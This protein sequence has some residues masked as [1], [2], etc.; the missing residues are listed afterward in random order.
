MGGAVAGLGAL[1]GNA[2]PGAIFGAGKAGNALGLS[3]DQGEFYNAQTAN[4]ALDQMNQ[5]NAATNDPTLQNAFANYG[6]GGGSTQGLLNQINGAPGAQGLDSK[7]AEADNNALATGALTGSR[8]ATEQV[9]NN[10]IEGQL[11][12][13]NGLFGKEIGKEQDL[14]NQGFQLQP[15]DVEAYGQASGNISRLFGQQGQQAS[16]DL[17]SR[18]LAAGPSGAAGA[19]FSGLAGNKNEMLG[20]AQMQIANQRMQ[21]TMQRIGQ[22]QNFINSLGAQG[23]NDIQQQYGRQ[24]AGAQNS[25][26]NL[27]NAANAQN[28]RNAGANAAGLASM[29]DK[30]NSAGKTLGGALGAGIYNGVSGG[31]GN[32]TSGLF[33][34]GGKDN[35]ALKKFGGGAGGAG[36]GGAGLAG[37]A[38]EIA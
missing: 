9:Q 37:G 13:Q 8:Y 5:N 28:A 10:P 12:G 3:G 30:R 36:G 34:G 14:Q 26:G 7:S 19:E 11:F 20:Q 22:Q 29:E 23:A 17:A 21:N 31:M 6:Q 4:P 25:Q 1:A 15:Q 27:E 2:V 38:A 33:G 18:G 16:Q 24:L 32:F 35:N